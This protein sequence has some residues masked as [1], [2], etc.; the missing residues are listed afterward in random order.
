MA[1]GEEIVLFTQP[2]YVPGGHDQK[3]VIRKFLDVATFGGTDKAEGLAERQFGQKRVSTFLETFREYS[4]STFTG[5]LLGFM[6]GKGMIEVGG[7]PL[8]AAGSLAGFIG[9]IAAGADSGIGKTMGDIGANCNTIYWFR[10]ADRWSRAKSGSKAHGDYNPD[11]DFSG[12]DDPVIE[13][14]K[15]L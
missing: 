4:E 3:S 10:M 8:D 14:G 9:R 6:N 7:V 12:E 1:R 15:Q 13:A 11:S 5:G 2:R